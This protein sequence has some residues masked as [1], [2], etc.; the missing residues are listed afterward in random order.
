MKLQFRLRTLMIVVTLLAVCCA[1]IAR[2][3]ER[4][5]ERKAALQLLTNIGGLCYSEIDNR[6]SSLVIELPRE[7]TLAD[8]RRIAAAFP[9]ANILIWQ[10]P[11]VHT[12]SVRKGDLV[13]SQANPESEI[14][15][16]A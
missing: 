2:Q 11:M 12:G 9:D 1:L 3:L 13:R 15:L 7:S 6:D 8:R 16:A 14:L 4:D 10:V 5:R